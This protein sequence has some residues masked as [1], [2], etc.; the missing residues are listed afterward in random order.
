MKSEAKIRELIER[1]QE[2][3]DYVG[4]RSCDEAP[5]IGSKS[6]DWVDGEW[7]ESQLGGLCVTDIDSDYWHQMHISKD[8][9]ALGSG[10][11]LGDSYLIAGNDDFGSGVDMGEK[12]ISCE[13][14]IKL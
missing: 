3:F 9:N 4:I 5:E 1:L 8:F 2:E 6:W 7:T 14:V 13:R 11:Y 12:I 10:S